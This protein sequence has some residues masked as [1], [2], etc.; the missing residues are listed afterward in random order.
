MY[1]RKHRIPITISFNSYSA[2][3]N[4]RYKIDIVSP[5]I[6]ARREIDSVSQT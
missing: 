6:N 2:E 1:V 3:E 4:D 5:V